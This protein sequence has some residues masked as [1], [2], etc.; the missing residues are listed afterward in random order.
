[1][2]VLSSSTPTFPLRS[3]GFNLF[4]MTCSQVPPFLGFRQSNYHITFPAD[5]LKRRRSNKI[6]MRRRHYSPTMS[7]TVVTPGAA[8]IN[9]RFSLE[10]DGSY[11]PDYDS[12][13]YER[14]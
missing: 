11:T 13:V 5:S 10:K 6:Q 12:S 1:M 7:P 2:T 8:E 14:L 3:S 9:I 4:N